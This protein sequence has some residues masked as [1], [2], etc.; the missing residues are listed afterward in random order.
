MNELEIYNTDDVYYFENNESDTLVV[1]FAGNG[2]K[3]Y[4]NRPIFTFYTMFKDY[5]NIDKLFIRDF[6]CYYYINVLENHTK[7]LEETVK[8]IENLTVRRNYKKIIAIGCSSGGFAAILFG[9]LLKFDKVLAFGP[10][11]V[12]SV[13]KESE[14]LDSYM[15][16][17]T[18]KFLRQQN[19]NNEFYQKCLNLKNFIPFDTKIELHYSGRANYGCDKRYANYIESENCKLIEHNYDNHNVAKELKN[20]DKLKHIIDNAILF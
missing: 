3:S 20:D 12:L 13:E 2:L 14:I 18:C 17:N 15:N 5:P 19:K 11:T 16:V 1:S 10:Q 8:F 9:H 4:G 7:N 6:K